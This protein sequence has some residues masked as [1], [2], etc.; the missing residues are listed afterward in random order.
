MATI[1]DSMRTQGYQIG[2]SILCIAK[3]VLVKKIDPESIF[4]NLAMSGH[5]RAVARIVI[6]AV[7][8]ARGMLAQRFQ[9]RGAESTPAARTARIPEA[10]TPART[11]S[12]RIPTRILDPEP[13]S[14]AFRIRYLPEVPRPAPP[15]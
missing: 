11:C 8:L 13:G 4:A 14:E 2:R 5:T 7:A 15:S 1:V 6:V 12:R 10:V 9:G 3:S